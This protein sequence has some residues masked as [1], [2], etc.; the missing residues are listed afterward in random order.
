MKTYNFADVEAFLKKEGLWGTQWFNTRNII[1]DPMETIYCKDGVR[2]DYC[3]KYCYLEIFG[4]EEEDENRL[5]EAEAE[6]EK[7]RWS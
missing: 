5:D 3:Y 7:Q 1:G 2:I 4:L 6:A